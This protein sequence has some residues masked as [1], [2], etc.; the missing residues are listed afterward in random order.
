MKRNATQLPSN[1]ELEKYGLHVRL[2]REEDAEFILQLRT[3]PLLSR[4]LHATK[5]NLQKQKE[6]IRDYKLREAKGEDYYFFI[7]MTIVMLESIVCII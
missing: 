5:N 2:V 1:F 7:P 3:D 4:F 6:W